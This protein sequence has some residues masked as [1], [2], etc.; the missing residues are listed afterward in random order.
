[1]R[2][3]KPSFAVKI[4]L[5]GFT[6]ALKRRGHSYFCAWP[7][8]ICICRSFPFRR[9]IYGRTVLKW[10]MQLDFLTFALV[11]LLVFEPLFNA[12]KK[13]VLNCFSLKWL[14]QRVHGRRERIFSTCIHLFWMPEE[15]I[16]WKYRLPDHVIF[17]LLCFS[18]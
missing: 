5:S 12:Q 6:K 18:E 3:C 1:M 2:Q 9:N 16:I 14:E 11:K 15:H 17:N 10:I 8:W 13:H 4:V 7:Y